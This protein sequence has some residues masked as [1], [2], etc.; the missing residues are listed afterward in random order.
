MFCCGEQGVNDVQDCFAFTPCQAA[1]TGGH[2]KGLRGTLTVDASGFLEVCAGEIEGEREAIEGF[3]L[4][5]PGVFATGDA[6]NGAMADV[7]L[8]ARGRCPV[9]ERTSW[10][11][12]FDKAGHDDFL[13]VVSHA[14]S[15][16]VGARYGRALFRIGVRPALWHLHSGARVVGRSWVMDRVPVAGLLGEV[17][18]ESAKT[19][20]TPCEAAMHTNPHGLHRASMEDSMPRTSEF[21][22]ARSQHVLAACCRRP[23]QGHAAG[24]RIRI[25]VPLHPE[26]VLRKP[27][28]GPAGRMRRYGPG[29]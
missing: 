16:G 21:S 17:H 15:P 18:D 25:R 28:R 27:D 23:R 6:A 14:G 29:T 10:G 3:L 19:P 4:K 20:A 8:A 7:A 5:G 9:A 13:E 24:C 12:E 1:G 26:M 22:Q 2:Y 11:T